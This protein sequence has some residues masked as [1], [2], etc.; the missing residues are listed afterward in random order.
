MRAAG[1][2]PHRRGAARRHVPVLLARTGY[3]GEDGVEIVCHAEPRGR[4]LAPAAELPRG[5]ARA[6]S[7]RA[8]R[9]ASRWATR[10]TAAT[11][12]G[13]STRSRPGSGWVVSPRQGRLRRARGHRARSASGGPER[14]LVGLDGRRRRPAARVSPCCTRA[15][16]VGTVASGTLLADARTRHRDGVRAG[17]ARGRRARSLEVAI[18]REGRRRRSC[19]KLPFV[20]EHVAVGTRVAD[21]R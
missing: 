5:H 7:A 3:T 8:T 16:E 1:A 12:T 2:V 18:R 9:C 4:G 19:T 17:R 6:G 15:S 13:R 11:S 14:R 10:C 20:T 21:R